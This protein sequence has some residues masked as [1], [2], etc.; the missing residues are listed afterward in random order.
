MPSGNMGA[1]LRGRREDLGISLDMAASATNIRS[2]MLSV[3]EDGDYARFPPY[4][5]ALGMV[6]S[7]ARYLGLDPREVL[8]AFEREWGAYERSRDMAR[9]AERSRRGVGAYGE[10]TAA[11]MRPSQRT[12]AGR[13]A[14]G[15]ARAAMGRED[16][17]MRAKLDDERVAEHDDRY[18]S[19]TVK[20]V[21]RRKT[22]AMPRVGAPSARRGGGAGTGARTSAARGESAPAAASGRLGRPERG[23]RVA[24]GGAAG[25]PRATEGH[26]G[27][28]DRYRRER[29][30]RSG[31][32]GARDGGSAA[33]NHP[34]GPEEGAGS[35]DFF[36]PEALERRSRR[37]AGAGGSQGGRSR[38]AEGGGDRGGV[39]ARA[40]GVVSE[41][42][43]ERRTRLIAIGVVAFVLVV[44]IVAGILIST[45][46]R[47]DA[48]VIA[49]DGGAADTTTTT[50]S[51]DSASATVTTTNGN[52]IRVSIDVAEGQTS[53][54]NV[55]Y[56]GDIDYHG[57]AVGAWHREFLVTE[58]FSA[59]FGNP[60]AVSVTENG[61]PVA[62]QKNDDGTGQL[63]ITIKTT[64]TST[65]TGSA[66]SSSQE[67]SSKKKSSKKSKK[68]SK[69]GSSGSEGS[70]GSQG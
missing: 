19:G 4:G 70:S 38:G 48:G 28:T 44:A 32:R 61:T 49:V 45:A 41:A 5:H 55:T 62:V 56:D 47:D 65:E 16:S 57:T 12:G 7:Y 1:I 69:K 60:D 54:V 36:S 68:S 13:A 9:S 22:G 29:Y 11:G 30:V 46:G 66:E 3:I 24:R 34:P 42:L 58:S 53:L 35:R 20:V 23:D 2:R 67:G 40:A 64:S 63:S 14:P 17:A 15:E 33:R 37:A 59:T 10:R 43:S 18:V 6:S 21:G 51:P 27:R 50:S 39:L 52:P 25:T 31:E 8:E 26:P